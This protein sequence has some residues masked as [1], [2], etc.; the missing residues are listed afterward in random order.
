MNYRHLSILER[1][2]ISKMLSSG[3]K[4]S[5]IAV[6]L[7]RSRGTISRELKR[8]RDEGTKGRYFAT[9]AQKLY[10]DRR[11]ASKVSQP[12]KLDDGQLRSF[13][14]RKLRQQWS[15][16]QISGRLKVEQPLGDRRVSHQTIYDFVRSDKLSGGDLHKHL[17]QSGKIRR[18]KYGSSLK[19]YRVQN[20]TMIAECPKVANQR[21]RLGDWEGDT[22]VGKNHEGCFLTQVD[23]KSRYLLAAKLKDRTSLSVNQAIINHLIELPRD[24]RRTLTVDNGTEFTRFDQLEKRLGLKVYFA[25]P[26]HSWERGTNENTNELIRQ[27]FKKSENLNKV[28]HQQLAGVVKKLNNRP[29][30]CLNFKTPREVLFS[31]D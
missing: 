7:N 21:H 4:A 6:L 10:V 28:S 22:I 23:R 9:V 26:Y 1:E 17:R 20:R 29:R 3:L 11:R 27:Y 16:E 18:K 2:A 19:K 8:N 24:F 5:E 31:T 13:V 15:P 30:K 25:H 14:R 12:R